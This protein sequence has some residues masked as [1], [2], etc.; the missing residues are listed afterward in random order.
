MQASQSVL[1]D[2]WA[3]DIFPNDEGYYDLLQGMVGY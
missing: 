3:D 2:I 1:F